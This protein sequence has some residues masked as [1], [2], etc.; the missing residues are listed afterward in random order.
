VTILWSLYGM[1][2][3]GENRDRGLCAIGL[4][5]GIAAGIVAY[6]VSAPTPLP[7]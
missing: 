1:Y 4:V 3:E 6:L 7:R 2:R 5:M